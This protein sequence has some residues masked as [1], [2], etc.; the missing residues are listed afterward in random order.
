MTEF[1]RLTNGYLMTLDYSKLRLM[2]VPN[3]LFLCGGK[4]NTYELSDGEKKYYSMRGAILDSIVTSFSQLSQKLQ[5]AED[6]DDWLEHGTV[7]NLIDFE[8]AIAD[9]AGAIVLVL[10]GPGAFA[11]L[12][13]FS[14]LDTLAD[15]LILI[16]NT[17]IVEENTFINYGPIKYLEDNK[18]IV[19]K[20]QWDVSYKVRGL[21]Q[22]SVDS[23][24]TSDI[25]KTLEI[26]RRITNRIDEEANKLSSKSPNLD[27]KKIGHIC[28]V[29]GDLIYTF[30]A[31]KLNEINSFLKEYFDIKSTQS[32]VK[33]CIYILERFSFIKAIDNGDR[34]YIATVNNK[35]FV[36]HYY[37]SNLKDMVEYENRIKFMEGL[38]SIMPE[39]DENRFIS[40]T[41]N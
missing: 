19:L 37:T 10:E 22:N 6:Y 38:L 29:V 31:L 25:N 40:I 3:F 17:N 9:M 41:E 21:N 18:K 39:Y 20:Y 34:Y 15:K 4:T 12:G 32:F 8:L 5:Y 13:S 28:F 14:V 27:I 16:V 24:I 7:K 36:K 26:A 30:G 23:R 11:E 1:E 35:G 2:N 33:T